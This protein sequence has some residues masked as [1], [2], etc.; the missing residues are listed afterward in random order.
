M[1]YYN[2]RN[3]YSHRYNKHGSILFLHIT[4][5]RICSFL[6]IILNIYKTFSRDIKYIYIFLYKRFSFIDTKINVISFWCV[7][8]DWNQMAGNADNQ[9]T[10]FVGNDAII[11]DYDG[12]AVYSLLYSRVAAWWI[13]CSIIHSH[14]TMLSLYGCH[15]AGQPTVGP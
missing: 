7:Y 10:R 12:W 6:V 1:L 11:I 3:Y 4:A 15:L 14:W 5:Y 8:K 2:K 13:D 9:R